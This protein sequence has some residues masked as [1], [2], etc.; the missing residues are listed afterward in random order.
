MN[1][2]IIK[3][4]KAIQEID[5]DF[6]DLDNFEVDCFEIDKQRL[7]YRYLTAVSNA[8]S[9]N[10]NLDNWKHILSA[11][12]SSNENKFKVISVDSINDKGLHLTVITDTQFRL[13]GY[14][15]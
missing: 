10:S 3:T 6:L 15:W 4:L 7:D 8:T 13:L 11:I 9:E 14:H 12:R 1:P 5:F 2:E